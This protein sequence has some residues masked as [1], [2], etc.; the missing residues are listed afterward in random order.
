MLVR[1]QE[2]IA[3][4]KDLL[5][6][7]TAGLRIRPATPASRRSGTSSITTSLIAHQ[8]MELMDKL[9]HQPEAFRDI[10]PVFEEEKPAKACHRIPPRPGSTGCWRITIS[11]PVSCVIASRHQSGSPRRR[12]WFHEPSKVAIYLDGMSKGRCTAIRR[13]LRRINSSGARIELQGYKVI[14]VQ[15]RDLNDPQAVRQHLK[16]IAQALGRS[17]LAEAIQSES[18]STSRNGPRTRL[19]GQHTS[20]VKKGCS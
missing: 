10:V 16:N 2:L 18:N 5:A 1:W 17:D 15:S 9:D 20:D 13:P 12:T 11:R 8:A 3:S 7:C 6:G 14:V 4:A 19:C